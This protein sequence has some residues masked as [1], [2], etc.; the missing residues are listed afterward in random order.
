MADSKLSTLTAATTLDDT[1]IVF[2]NDSGSTVDRKATVATLRS[3][4]QSKRTLNTQT[5]SYTLVAGDAGKVVEQN[6][7]TANNLTVPP[8]S[9]VP[10]PTGTELHVIQLGAGATTIVAGSGVTLNSL[11]GNLVLPGQ[12]G[13]AVLRKRATDEWEVVVHGVVPGPRELARSQ[14]TTAQSGITTIT[15]IQNCSISFNVVSYPVDVELFCPWISSATG[16]VNGDVQVYDTTNSAIKAY[17]LV[18]MYAAAA[19]TAP[20]RAVERITTPGPHVRK[21]RVE[22]VTGTGTLSVGVSTAEPATGAW[23]RAVEVAT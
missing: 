9:S 18:S 8:N 5:G 3:A 22:R 13:W 17:G 21:G 15:D 16:L 7:A 19:Y 12:Y 14:M 2:L 10:F 6:V 23:I 20:G 11:S 4:V 1:D